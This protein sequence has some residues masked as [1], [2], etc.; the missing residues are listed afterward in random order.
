MICN[1]CGKE[2]QDGN[3]FCPY[4]GSQAQGA[5]GGNPQMQYQGGQQYGGMQQ[6]QGGYGMP[7]QGQGG[8]GMPQ[9]QGGYGMPQQGQFGGQGYGQPMQ[10]QAPRMQ[11]PGM[12]NQG[13][14]GSS[15]VQDQ[16]RKCP[17][18]GNPVGVEVCSTY[19]GTKL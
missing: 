16:G 2:Y 4:C 19:C 11:N 14:Q 1:V 8:Y 5:Q 12:Q 3:A 17:K 18:C 7:Q 9:G 15:Y 13:A 6:G 10:N